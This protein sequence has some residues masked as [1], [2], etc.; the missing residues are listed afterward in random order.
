MNLTLA[1]IAARTEQHFC[2]IKHA[3]RIRDAHEHYNKFFEFG[4]AESFAKGLE[5]IRKEIENNKV[6]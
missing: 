5:R 2:P 6:H 4:D 3:R 1:E